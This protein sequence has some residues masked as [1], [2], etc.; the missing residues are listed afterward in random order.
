MRTHK[1]FKQSKHAVSAVIGVILMV[2]VTIAMAAVAY[3]YFTGMIGASPESKAIVSMHQDG[4]SIIVS[5]I[6]NGPVKTSGLTVTVIDMQT[7]QP[8][9]AGVM[10]ATPDWTIVAPDTEVNSGDIITM[11]GTA[12]A[13]RTYTI[14]LVYS[15]TIIG[16]CTFIVQ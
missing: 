1:K 2:A 9:A 8:A 3:A 13:G 10:D 11:S 15:D 7:G 4:T 12:T 5:E 16:T 6:S 14:N